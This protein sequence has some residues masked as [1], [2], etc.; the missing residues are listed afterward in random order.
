MA[1]DGDVI[2]MQEPENGI[3]LDSVG[4]T[5]LATNSQGKVTESVMTDDKQ[6][7]KLSGE[8][9]Q[10]N[11]SLVTIQHRVMKRPATCRPGGNQKITK[12]PITASESKKSTAGSSH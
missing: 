1:S 8:K 4:I 5:T 3:K 7:M 6:V 12:R 10:N 9:R 11:V 2:I